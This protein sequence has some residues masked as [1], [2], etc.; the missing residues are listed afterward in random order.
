ML[1][2][3]GFRVVSKSVKFI[4]HHYLSG[5][6]SALIVFFV[7]IETNTIG[8]AVPKQITVSVFVIN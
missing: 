7:N 4:F 8:T 6:K 3:V 2:Y 5:G 1:F